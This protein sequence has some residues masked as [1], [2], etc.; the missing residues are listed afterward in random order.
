MN[1]GIGDPVGA[2][3][4][5]VRLRAELRVSD[6]RAGAKLV[7]VKR[8]NGRVFEFPYDENTYGEWRLWLSNQTHGSSRSE[9]YPEFRHKIEEV[10]ERLAAPFDV[11]ELC[12]QVQ[13][14]NPDPSV[15]AFIRIELADWALD[16]IPWELLAVPVMRE[17]G[18]RNVCVYRAVRAKKRQTTSPLP[19][20]QV[21][22]VD[23]AP[24]SMQS[25]HFEPEENAIRRRLGAM[26]I[27][28]LVQLD[29]C[30]SADFGKLSAR[31]KRPLRLVHIAAQ[32]EAGIVYLSQGKGG[33]QF[34]SRTF[35]EIFDRE[36][37]PVA[38][39][40]SVCDS[41][42]A[43]STEPGVARAVADVGVMEVIGMFSL[44]TPTAA[45]EFFDSLYEALGRCS[46]MTIAYAQAVA[47]LRDNDNYPDCGF[48]SVPVLYSPFNVIPFPVALDE[49]RDAY[50]K[51]A[52][53]IAQ[54][55]ADISALCP[56]ESWNENTW[57]RNTMMLRARAGARRRGLEQ[58]SRLVEP[59]VRSGSRWAEDVSHAA[60]I[61]LRSFNGVISHA[62]RAKSGAS[63]T[64]NFVE[65]KTQLESALDELYAAL[66][67]RL[68][69]SH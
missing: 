23:S 45:L 52:V 44:I 20:Q 59:E 24:L 55:R 32:G 16:V 2:P 3:G 65:L 49:P 69:F 9:K 12:R 17:L 41:A 50:H 66:S 58:L 51:I 28:G 14:I 25:P 34:S 27:A 47:T 67:A 4:H 29:S 5:A 46:N 64:L 33:V 35:A 61:G 60:Y 21:L 19:P 40:F 53:E 48:W 37:Q 39:I 10:A 43:T 30:P 18:G 56:D 26:K 54:L 42:Q 68:K 38:A 13:A 11:A 62:N 1:S 6:N 57:Q 31:M 22:L 7:A 36:P 8:A 15:T 63:S